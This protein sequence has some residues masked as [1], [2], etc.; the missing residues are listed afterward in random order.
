MH[1][2]A[3]IL[4]ALNTEASAEADSRFASSE[5]HAVAGE[6]WKVT[7]DAG[8]RAVIQVETASVSAWVCGEFTRYADLPGS[9]ADCLARFLADDERGLGRPQA[10]HGQFAVFLRDKRS[11]CWRVCTDRCGTVHV[12]HV[13]NSSGSAIGTYS[14]AVYRWSNRRLDWEGLAC[15]FASGFFAGDRTHYDDVRVLRPRSMYNF[16]AAGKLL[17]QVQYWNWWHQ[18][19]RRRTP[20]D[21]VAEMADVL[22]GIVKEQTQ[23]VRTAL[24]LSAGL[25]SR[26][27]AACA[28]LDGSVLAYSYGYTSN[29][30]ETSI[31]RSIAQARGLRFTAFTVEPYLLDRVEDVIRAVEGFQ[32]VTQARQAIVSDWLGENADVVLGGHWGDVLCDSMGIGA[33]AMSDAEIRD[34]AVSKVQKRGRKWLLDNLCKSHF[35]NDD[36]QALASESV[37]AGLNEFDTIE[38]PDFRVK[39]FKTAQ[40]AFR[41]TL[42][43]LRMY[44]A[45]AFPR[46]PFLDPYSIDF[47]C[48]VPTEM[49]I[50]RKLQIEF[51]KRFAPSLAAIRWQA[52]DANLFELRHFNT[53]LAPRRLWNKARRAIDSRPVI[54]RNWEAQFLPPE[55]FAKLEDRLTR[56]GAPIGEFV[57]TAAIRK[58][59]HGLRNE[60]NPS[61]GYAVSML[62]TFAV[63]LETVHC[64]SLKSA[65]AALASAGAGS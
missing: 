13:S 1:A 17:S 29:S 56:P 8:K 46:L 15:F 40:W 11:G 3:D 22:S 64:G 34:H 16:D 59:I 65:D 5:R 45:G 27:L 4:I 57:S 62:L 58:L 12:Y 61:D 2:F 48:T 54:Q 52:Y 43:S 36:P 55:E 7:L 6:G 21:T 53:W 41:W 51:L 18:P 37:G 28:P 20:E 10:L 38:D 30:V 39:C 47:F 44:Q 60:P 50:G 24:P 31:S 25:D 9:T 23:G 14:P 33:R 19:D 35:G 49:V 32:D 26:T 63:W 42:A